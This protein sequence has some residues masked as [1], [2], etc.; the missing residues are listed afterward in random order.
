LHKF[1]ELLPGLSFVTV[2]CNI[3][4]QDKTDFIDRDGSYIILIPDGNFNKFLVEI[5]G[6]ATGRKN[7]FTS[8]WNYEARFVVAGAHE[9]SMSQKRDIFL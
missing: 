5:L 2:D 6:L 8:F 3:S 4:K 1:I 7:E 9:F